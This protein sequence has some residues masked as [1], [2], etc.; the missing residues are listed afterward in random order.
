MHSVYFSNKVGKE[1]VRIA[2][3]VGL[4]RKTVTGPEVAEDTDKERKVLQLHACEV[5]ILCT[6]IL[7]SV[8][9]SFVGE[10]IY[11]LQANTASLL[12]LGHF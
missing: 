9:Y 8:S 10:Y 5:S 11:I 7:F 2:E 12:H 3:S 1:R 4:H 6:C